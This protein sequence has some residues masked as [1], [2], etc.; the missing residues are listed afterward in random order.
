MALILTNV[1]N[2]TDSGALELDRFC[3]A[4]KVIDRSS[5]S[6]KTPFD[7]GSGTRRP[8]P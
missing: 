1:A 2:V 5:P 7:P 8:I 6:E 3:E 4:N